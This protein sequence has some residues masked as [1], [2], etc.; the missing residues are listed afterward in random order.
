MENRVRQLEALSVLGQ[1]RPLA[2]LARRLFDDNLPER[3]LSLFEEVELLETRLLREALIS[4]G[5]NK[6]E[7]AR[8][9]SIHESTFR[10]KM[11]RYQLEGLVN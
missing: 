5:G 8:I 9:L 10:A 1:D 7:A 11:K 6:S 3:T 2:E 4:T